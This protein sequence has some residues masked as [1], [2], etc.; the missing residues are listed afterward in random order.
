MNSQ[1]LGTTP[2][3]KRSATAV[4]ASSSVAKEAISVTR[5]AGSGRS[6]RIAFVT[7]ASVPSLPTRSCVRL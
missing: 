2:C 1:A 4:A 6:R 7:T 5:A 3:P